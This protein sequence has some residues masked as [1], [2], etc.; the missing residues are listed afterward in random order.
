MGAPDDI[1]GP[2]PTQGPDSSTLAGVWPLFG[3]R[4]VHDDLEL[5]PVTDDDAV[6]LADLLEDP[7]VPAGQEYFV[8]RLLI[9]RAATRQERAQEMLRYHWTTRAGTRPERWEVPFAVVHD[10]TVVG[11]QSSRAEDFAVVGNVH[12]GSF[13]A[14]SAQG[15]G[16]GGRMRAMVLEW[17]FAHLGAVG[18]SS[19]YMTGNERSARI[20]ARLGYEP[21]G[22]RFHAF[23]GVRRADHRLRLTRQRWLDRRPSWLDAMTVSGMEP[24]RGLLGADAR[25]EPGNRP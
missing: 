3:L 25:A 11:T 10:G 20:S 6:A 16:I 13:L 14:G 22:V 23:E 19:G 4:L 5:R 2:G 17:A 18:V 7:I 12:T 15:R 9:G 8:P 21:D 1:S 24:C